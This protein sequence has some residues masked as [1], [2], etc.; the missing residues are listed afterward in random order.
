VEYGTNPAG[1]SIARW[2]IA[3]PGAETQLKSQP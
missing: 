2:R 1:V 3:V